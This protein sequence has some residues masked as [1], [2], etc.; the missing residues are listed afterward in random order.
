MLNR[1]PSSYLKIKETLKLKCKDIKCWNF[2]LTSQTF[3]SFSTDE[4]MHRPVGIPLKSSIYRFVSCSKYCSKFKYLP[5]H[6]LTKP[7]SWQSLSD[8]QTARCL[9]V[10]LINKIQLIFKK[11]SL[12]T[13]NYFIAKPLGLFRFQKICH[14]KNTRKFIWRNNVVFKKMFSYSW[15][16]NKHFMHLKKLYQQ[17]RAF[18]KYNLDSLRMHSWKIYYQ[19]PYLNR[20]ASHLMEQ[21]LVLWLW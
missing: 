12:K 1:A 13:V 18:Y 15:I 17:C 8:L 14:Y 7:I 11:V 21:T 10:S 4:L 3:T 6:E 19:K 20:F 16:K 9:L 2:R 5:F